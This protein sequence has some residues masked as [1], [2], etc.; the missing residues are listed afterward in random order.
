MIGRK[1]ERWSIVMC[2]PY[3]LNP[4]PH[5]HPLVTSQ[6]PSHLPSPLPPSRY[7][8]FALM[9]NPLSIWLSRIPLSP[10]LY[11]IS[12]SHFSIQFC[13]F[14]FPFTFFAF[15]Q[16]LS[17]LI[18]MVCW[19]FLITLLSYLQHHEQKSLNKNHEYI[20][21]VKNFW[22]DK[23]DQLFFHLLLSIFLRH[24]RKWVS[25]HIANWSS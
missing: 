8:N 10:P 13:R 23:C 25:S 1:W 7:L 21:F 20:R 11:P 19:S 24:K 18:C 2:L 22:K 5:L 9:N 4:P 12:L 15:F 3:L 6:P 16:F 14:P 17:L